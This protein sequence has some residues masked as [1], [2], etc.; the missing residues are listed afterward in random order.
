MMY[1]FIIV[2]FFFAVLGGKKNAPYKILKIIIKN[3]FRDLRKRGVCQTSL[4]FHIPRSARRRGPGVW[5]G[6]LLWRRCLWQGRWSRR[7]G[8]SI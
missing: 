6:F 3:K 4:R 5:L 8:E 1:F 7:L 2:A